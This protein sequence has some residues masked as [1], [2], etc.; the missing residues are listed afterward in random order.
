M[1]VIELASSHLWC[2]LFVV[3][4]ADEEPQAESAVVVAGGGFDFFS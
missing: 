4:C 1:V 2:T 3:I